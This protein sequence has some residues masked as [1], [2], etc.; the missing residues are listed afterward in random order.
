MKN[1]CNLADFIINTGLCGLF[2]IEMNNRS[3]IF[4]IYLVNV[5]ITRPLVFCC[6]NNNNTAFIQHLKSP[7]KDTEAHYF[8]TLS[9]SFSSYVHN[10][11]FK[12][13]YIAI[14]KVIG[15]G[16]VSTHCGP[17]RILMML[18]IYNLCLQCFDTVGR[19]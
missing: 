19:H 5:L 17:E 15:I 10:M 6:Y 3:L 9:S 16:Q 2:L 14:A 1:T 8:I 13:L 12:L 4:G 11:S 7:V 18:G